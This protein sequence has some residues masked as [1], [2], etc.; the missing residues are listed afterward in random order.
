M[1]I[2]YVNID[3]GRNKRKCTKCKV[4]FKKGK[5]KTGWIAHWMIKTRK[6]YG[7]CSM[8]RKGKN[9]LWKE[10]HS[11]ADRGAHIRKKNVRSNNKQFIVPACRSCNGFK[12]YNMDFK[13]KKGIEH[14][15][16]RALKEDCDGTKN[17]PFSLK[18][19]NTKTRRKSDKNYKKSIK[20]RSRLKNKR[21]SKKKI[22]TKSNPYR[23]KSDA[24]KSR[25]TGMVWYYYYGNSKKKRFMKK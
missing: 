6:K 5:D 21:K 3:H 10:C 14:K 7:K 25:K 17:L 23:T 20:V 15:R 22:G 1:G 11:E 12:S 13:L 24:K 8:I 19:D 9:G 2:I 16:I 4:I 18:S